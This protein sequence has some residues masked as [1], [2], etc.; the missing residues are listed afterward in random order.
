MKVVVLVVIQLLHSTASVI[1]EVSNPK[2]TILMLLNK[3]LALSTLIKSISKS[4]GSLMCLLIK[5]KSKLHYCNNLFRFAWT[6]LMFLSSSTL[7]VLSL[8]VKMEKMM[9]L[10]TAFWWLVMVMMRKSTL[11]IGSSKTSGEPPGV[12]MDTWESRETIMIMMDQVSASLSPK[13]DI[14]WMFQV[15]TLLQI[16][17]KH[18]HKT[19]D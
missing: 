14:L 15:Q 16:E 6:A 11:I 8:N 17:G 12:K 3:K 10:I 4:L 18:S 13:W 19:L 5:L 7:V 2:L 9:V 1:S